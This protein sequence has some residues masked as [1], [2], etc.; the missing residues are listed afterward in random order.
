MYQMLSDMRWARCTEAWEAQTLWNASSTHAGQVKQKHNQACIGRLAR[1][2]CMI[3]SDH[4]ENH[5]R[6]CP[7][8]TQASNLHAAGRMKNPVFECDAR[9]NS[10]GM[11]L[12]DTI[13]SDHAWTSF[14]ADSWRAIPFAVVALLR[15][16]RDWAALHRSFL[17]QLVATGAAIILPG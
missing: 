16:K 2:L 6:P 4:M 10:L 14:G 7:P 9:D 15:E 8:E 1:W 13:T 11:P 12:L 5:D 3:N 17:T